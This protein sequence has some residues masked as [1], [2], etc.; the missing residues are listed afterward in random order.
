[1]R[2]FHSDSDLGMHDCALV[3]VCD[4]VTS[5]KN[6]WRKLFD[7]S[8]LHIA[9]VLKLL[10][11]KAQAGVPLPGDGQRSKDTTQKVGSQREQDVG[12]K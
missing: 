11:L 10:I 1:M 7:G 3:V 9:L 2:K 4:N 6:T 12:V 8:C 5:R